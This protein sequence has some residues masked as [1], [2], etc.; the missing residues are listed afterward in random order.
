MRSC[1]EER[2]ALSLKRGMTMLRF[3]LG[4]LT[5]GRINQPSFEKLMSQALAFSLVGGV[6][7]VF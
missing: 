2:I 1:R 4:S 3:I 5:G 7:T 6:D